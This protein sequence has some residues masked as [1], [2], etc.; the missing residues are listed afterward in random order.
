M[1]PFV[2]L[3]WLNTENTEVAS[4]P[5][6]PLSSESSKAPSVHIGWYLTSGWEAASGS[7]V[8]KNV[9]GT[10]ETNLLQKTGREFTT[11]RLVR[12]SW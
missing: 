7:F 6:P 2:T 5:F 12:A 3:H 1:K 4:P 9:S 11:I 8:V 10:K